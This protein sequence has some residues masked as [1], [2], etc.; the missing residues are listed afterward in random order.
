MRRVMLMLSS[1]V[2][3]LV[4][5][6]AY[7][8]SAPLVGAPTLPTAGSSRVD[9]R[10][11]N[12]AGVPELP[13]IGVTLPFFARRIWV[14]LMPRPGAV[15]S[16]PYDSAAIARSP[17]LTWIGHSTFL[18]RMDGVAFLTD[19]MF[20]DRASPF[21]FMGP[22]RMVPPGV[23]LEELP[24]VN[25]VLLSHDHYDHAD[26]RTVERLAERGVRF[27]VPVGLADWVRSAGGK[28]IELDWWQEIELDGLRIHCVPAQHF[29]GRSF[30]DQRRRLWAGWVVSGPSRRFYYAGDTGYSADF[31]A[32]GEQLGP[33]DLATVPIGAYLPAA[34]MHPVHTTP[35]EALQLGR[36]V[37][38][39]RIVA[40]HFGTFDLADE[41]LAEP[42]RR[43]RAE[44]E[45]LG[46]GP[47]RAW[48]MKVGETREW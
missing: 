34:M 17:S 7:A 47:D 42:P 36:D 14:T 11:T 28:A 24:P 29:S 9:G 15:S 2:L 43:F 31:K 1:V 10:F 46:L 6:L 38:A 22:R 23:P 35:E 27:V 8:R 33:F 41:P 44:A 48:V 12:H 16:V 25:F 39:A 45:R 5:A 20:S 37:N 32:I 21:S 4:V 40:M 3:V 13:G 26:R 19:P 30:R 18:V